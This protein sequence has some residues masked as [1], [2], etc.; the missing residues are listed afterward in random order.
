MPNAIETS[1]DIPALANSLEEIQSRV[2]AGR[3]SWASP[4]LLVAARPV[5]FLTIQSLIALFLFAL[6]RPA[7]MHRAGQWWNVYGTFV[8]IGCLVG[9]RFFTRRE[10]IRLRDLIGPI[11]LRHGRDLFIGL[12]IFLLICPLFLGGGVL[13]Q[14]L[15]YGS[16]AQ[17]T[18][19]YLTQ[20]HSLPIWAFVYS[21]TVWWVISSTTEEITFQG[22]ALPRLE[23]LTGRTWIAAL[24][25]GLLWAAQHSVLPFVADWRYLFFR[26]LAF[27]PG[28]LVLMLIYLRTRRL[29]PLIVAHWSM[30][31]LGAIMTQIH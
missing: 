26:L 8:D 12:G 21:V 5:L 14:R 2:A 9:L 11:R 13:A 30:D 27:I 19:V 28:V 15:L 1:R 23:A 24:V 4:L 29:A 31:I 7:P 25:V 16:L 6:H 17:S 18:S 22:Y 20:L 3:I 10:G